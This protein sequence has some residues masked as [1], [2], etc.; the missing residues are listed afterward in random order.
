MKND[1]SL[2]ADGFDDQTRGVDA[3]TPPEIL[4]ADT[5]VFAGNVAF[6]GG[7][8]HTRPRLR[9]LAQN[10]VAPA[11]PSITEILISSLGPQDD[12]LMVK[13][14][15]VV[16]ADPRYNVG[17]YN[18]EVNNVANPGFATSGFRVIRLPNPIGQI[19]S[20][21]E[22]FVFDGYASLW[23]SSRWTARVTFSD[24]K[25]FLTSGGQTRSPQSSVWGLPSPIPGNYYT[26]QGGWYVQYYENGSFTIEYPTP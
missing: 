22:V 3:A 2:L 13:I 17:R 4:P 7:L 11:I 20:L 26:T 16:V 18:G 1:P 19:G 5:A 15:G 25:I 6:R 12:D 10:G 24:G 14:D 8:P 23:R 21:V 9:E